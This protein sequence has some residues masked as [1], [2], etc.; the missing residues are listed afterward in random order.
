MSTSAIGS[1]SNKFPLDYYI[2]TFVNPKDGSD[3][4]RP[5]ATN[6]RTA[7]L[8]AVVDRAIQ[9]NFVRG[10]KSDMLGL[11]GGFCQTMKAMAEEGYILNLGW[12]YIGGNLTGTVDETGVLTSANGY[13]ITMRP[14]KDLK[15]DISN[16]SLTNIGINGVKAKIEHLAWVGSPKDLQIKKGEA[17]QGT[18]K[19]LTWSEGCTATV[20]YTLTDGSAHTFTMVPTESDFSHLKFA[21]PTDLDEVPAGTEIS[22]SF[23]LRGGN[24]EGAVMPTGKTVTLV[25]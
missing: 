22:F 5:V 6:R 8:P 4:F 11:F 18:G 14:S 13:R 24:P 16:F 19:N 9:G 20:A 2:G 10:K 7:D 21:W 1:G 3:I 17:I 23:R 25:A 12:F 15:V